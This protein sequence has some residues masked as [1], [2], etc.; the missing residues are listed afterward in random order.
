MNFI[1]IFVGFKEQMNLY[2]YIITDGQLIV[3]TSVKQGGTQ[4]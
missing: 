1:L 2:I 3:S 4:V